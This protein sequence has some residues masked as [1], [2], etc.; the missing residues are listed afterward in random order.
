[1]KNN[2]LLVVLLFT[3]KFALAQETHFSQFYA[4]SVYLNAALAGIEEESKFTL[5]YRNQWPQINNS[6]VTN[7]VSFESRLNKINGGFAINAFKDQA[8]DGMLSTTSLGGVYAHEI[9][10]N[11]SLTF[12]AGF[13]FSFVQKSVNWDELV[14]EDMI[15]SRQ[16]VIHESQQPIG[17]AISF[18]DLSAGGFLY[19][20]NY[21]A[22]FSIDH[23]NEAQSGLLN[24]NG[25]SK[26]S[27]RYTI[28]GGIKLNSNR[29]NQSLSP[30]FLI[31]K[32]AEFYKV[33]VGIYYNIDPLVLGMWYGSNQ[34]MVL[35]LGVRLNRF[36]FGYSYDLTTSKMIGSSL[37]SHEISITKSFRNSV[38]K[39]RFKTVSCPAF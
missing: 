10:I 25:S 14:F 13:R 8:G 30:N 34:T 27:R 5:N 31:S 4:S 29:R 26:L 28:H 36:Q 12:R 33:N 21:F 3:T 15:D 24:Q 18:L 20:E 39:K 32:Q 9:Q 19:G 16:G 2:Y 37:G 1:M 11:N 23:L 35:L 7:N 38:K 17:Q 22:G 6:F